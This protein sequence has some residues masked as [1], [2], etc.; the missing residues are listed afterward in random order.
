MNRL[1]YSILAGV[2][3]IFVFGGA[4]FAD[5]DEYDN[6]HGKHHSHEERQLVSVK[7]DTYSQECGA[8]HFAYQPW[9]LPS[10]SWEKIL[11]ELPSHFGEDIS[12]DEETQK[13]ID[14]YLTANAADR[15]AVKRSRKI[16]KSLR[17]W[18]PLRVSEIPYILEKHHD[19]DPTILDRPSIGTLGNCIACHTSAD[20]GNYDDDY[21]TIPR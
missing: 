8:C 15:V 18:T 10:G 9:L 21:V 6:D 7:N 4:G 5:D 1:K 14:Q 16:M 17:G 3:F 2:I 19:L 13:T 20:Q 11:G 12:L